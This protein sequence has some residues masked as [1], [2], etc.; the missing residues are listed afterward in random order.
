MLRQRTEQFKSRF[1]TVPSISGVPAL[2]RG[3]VWIIASV[4]IVGGIVYCTQGSS[5][6]TMEP[7]FGNRVLRDLEIDQLEIAFG[8][9]GLSGWQREEGSILVPRET[10]HQY[11]AA[12]EQSSA[13]P[14]ALKSGTEES[15][16][17]GH[18]F[19]SESA[20]RLRHKDAKAK[21][22]GNTIIATFADIA[23][24]SVDYDEKD[25]G[26]FDGRTIQSAS[27]VLVPKNGKPIAP[28]RISMIQSF[29]C[30]AYAGMDTDQVTVTDSS[31]RKTYDGSDAPETRQQRQAEYELEQRLTELLSGYRGLHIAVKC[32]DASSN[33]TSDEPS[34]PHAVIAKP[35]KRSKSIEGFFMHVSVGVPESQFHTQW[36]SDY[37]TRHPGDEA[38]MAPTD[39]E[40][41][42]VRDK[43]MDNIRDAIRPLV[44]VAGAKVDQTIQVWS[45]PD[46]IKPPAYAG[47]DGHTTGLVTILEWFR[48]NLAFWLSIGCLFLVAALFGFAAMWM[49]MR[50]TTIDAKTMKTSFESGAKHTSVGSN[51]KSS[52][53]DD[54]TLRDDLAD[55]VETNPELA[56]QIVHSWIA[57]AA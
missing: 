16:G 5:V 37:R 55:L 25:A 28:S 13:L 35:S 19:E 47:A 56:A 34:N 45:Y 2:S 52:L 17:G 39:Q 7:L 40:M 31:A 44:A 50:S 38:T 21:K 26:G 46:S 33:D 53:A 12:M 23:W 42:V 22:L 11:L 29:V 36:I 57:D 49:R 3:I 43:V 14:Y 18:Y 54:M 20:R 41:D 6:R 4:L 24:A 8:V 10:R 15:T 48:H 30:G 51:S 9:S 32:V 1:D 27:V